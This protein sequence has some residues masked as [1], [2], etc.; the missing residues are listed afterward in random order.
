M[1]LKLFHNARII[2]SY[3]PVAKYDWMLVENG[4][5]S[6]L[7]KKGEEPNLPQGRI[8]KVDL[9]G[10]TAIPGFVDAHMHLDSFGEY[11]SV[12]DLAGA[13]SIKE[14]KQRIA[15]SNEVSGW[16]LGHGWDE[17]LFS[18]NRLPNRQDL[19]SLFPDKPVYLSRVDLHS[20]VL[21]SKALE[22]LDLER[23]FP[24]S[25][26]L[27]KENG[28]TT[29]NVKENVFEHVNAKVYEICMSDPENRILEKGL[30]ELA[31]NGVTTV[32]FM[33]CS[34][35]VLEMLRTLRDKGRLKVRVRAYLNAGE[36]E[37][38]TGF[39]ND[40]M[41]SV[42]GVKLFSDGSFGTKSA[43][44]TLPYE[45]DP[46]NFGDE[47]TTVERMIYLSRMAEEK[48]LDVATHAIGDKALDNVIEAY[49]HLN[50]RHRIDHVAMVREDQLEKLESIGSVLVVQPHFII[51]DFWILDRLGNSS[52]RMLY[53]FNT[54]NS[55]G[56]QL[57]FSTDCPVEPINPWET[58]YAAITR[59]E[60]EGIPLGKVTPSE[61]VPLEQSLLSYTAGSAAALRESRLG[62]LRTGQKAD[63]V[64]IGKDPFDCTNEEIRE[65]ITLNAYVN[66]ELVFERS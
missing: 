61:K 4:T 66:G 38:F 57:S 22:M 64:V 35:K 12:A 11:L 55:R 21:N 53:N 13:N 28:A 31:R 29:G 32:G 30:D 54:L 45:D 49:R 39:E 6:L 60:E 63:F 62:S 3:N 27:V 8:E 19:D 52:A 16:I 26:N 56:L 18:E 51:T 1:V 24:D 36:L 58:V 34:L 15:R 7:G 42:T 65:I 41:L 14:M 37:E 59:G 47:I 10:M 33:C 5:V 17:H 9:N 40:H 25:K 43:L 23:I 46:S 48:D 20:G 44:L 2:A 50:G